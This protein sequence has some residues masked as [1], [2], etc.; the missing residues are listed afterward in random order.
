MKEIRWN[1]DKSLMLK[2]E[3]GVS[4]EEILAGRFLGIE[5]NISREA[6]WLMV[7]EVDNYIWV[8]PYVDGGDHFF[9][10]T[11]FPSRKHTKI[12]LRGV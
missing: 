1:A 12:Y 9:L 7:Y 11:A 4:F 8:V 5:K 6:Q 2:K 10:K 3:R